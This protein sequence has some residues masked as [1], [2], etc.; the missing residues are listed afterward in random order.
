MK[1]RGVI[2]LLCI[3]TLLSLLIGC[4]KT[5]T[6][7]GADTEKE[8]PTLHWAVMEWE[9]CAS[10]PELPLYVMDTG[11]LNQI[12]AQLK[13]KGYGFQLDMEY[14]LASEDQSELEQVR[15]AE[16]DY[17]IVTFDAMGIGAKEMEEMLLPL[18]GYMKDGEPLHKVYQQFSEQVW[19]YNQVEGHIYNLGRLTEILYPRYQITIMKAEKEPEYAPEALRQNEEGAIE[20]AVQDLGV[21]IKMA[22]PYLPVWGD[23]MGVQCR[24]HMIAPGVGL[25]IENGAGF[26]N[27]WESEVASEWLERELT[28]LTEGISTSIYDDKG[29]NNDKLFFRNVTTWPEIT[30]MFQTWPDGVTQYSANIPIYA[31]GH[32]VPPLNGHYTSVLKDSPYTQECLQLLAA[33]NTDQELFEAIHT[34]VSNQVGKQQVNEFLDLCN[35][36]AMLG[37]KD[38]LSGE[39]TKL[40]PERI[41]PVLGFTFDQ[42][43]VQAEVTA[44]RNMTR[45]TNF[46]IPLNH[47]QI[48]EEAAE[49]G[50][51][52]RSIIARS[53]QQ[54]MEAYKQDL[55]QAGIDRVIEEA[56]RQLAEWRAS[57]K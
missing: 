36:Q 2:L 35:Y 9:Q 39:I 25:D 26:E 49:T 56:N 53:W 23:E 52:I 40:P 54:Q 1:R 19:E 17:D 24:F 48:E 15:A 33:L 8:L 27:V 57:R 12:N 31:E 32:L 45:T 51:D 14:V 18:E 22:D 28:M 46:A 11:R 4:Q 13:E 3:S 29:W 42:G 38:L 10:N 20:K 47:L 16:K 7:T 30:Q 21:G 37:K 34:P 50:E 5:N 43:P 6:D 44:L 55:Q 41:S